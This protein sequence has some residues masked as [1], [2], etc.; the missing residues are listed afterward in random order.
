MSGDESTQDSL[1]GASDAL[2]IAIRE[3]E[4][5]ERIKRGV[6]PA[7]R[8]FADLA[9]DV[10]LAAEEV[11]RMARVEESAADDTSGSTAA[12][13]LPTIEETAP[14]PALAEIL[15]EWR[16]VERRL[17]AAQAATPEAAQLMKEFES[18]RDRYAAALRAVGGDS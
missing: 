18:L 3:V 1:R 13:A 9:R 6:R 15:A 4:A 8:R 14:Q 17:E 2:L 16:T 10:R 5:R 11:L 12:V 7:D